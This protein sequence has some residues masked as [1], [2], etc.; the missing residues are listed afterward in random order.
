MNGDNLPGINGCLIES[1]AIVFTAVSFASRG[2]VN[3]KE[4]GNSSVGPEAGS[5]NPAFPGK[6]S[7]TV[8]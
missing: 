6:A 7:V 5:Y 4:E 8:I 1:S 3:V 2:V